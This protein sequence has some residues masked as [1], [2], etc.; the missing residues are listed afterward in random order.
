M[1]SQAWLFKI[2]V[3]MS[4][5]RGALKNGDVQGIDFIWGL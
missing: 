3:Q 1:V 4:S 5:A 2:I